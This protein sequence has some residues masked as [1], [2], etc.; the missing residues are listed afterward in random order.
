[1][2]VRLL[3]RRCTFEGDFVVFSL[4]ESTLGENPIGSEES[5]DRRFDTEFFHDFASESLGR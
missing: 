3:N 5:S 4:P 2:F 1:M